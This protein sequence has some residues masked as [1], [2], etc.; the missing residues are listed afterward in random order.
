MKKLNAEWA[1][2]VQYT[3]LVKNNYI[4]NAVMS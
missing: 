2:V 4:L 3:A 1:R